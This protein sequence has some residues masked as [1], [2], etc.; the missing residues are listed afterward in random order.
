MSKQTLKK[1]NNQPVLTVSVVVMVALAMALASLEWW[2]VTG[3]WQ[4]RS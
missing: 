4:R 3:I 2:S 1:C